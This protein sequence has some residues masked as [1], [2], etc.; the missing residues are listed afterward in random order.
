MLDGPSVTAALQSCGVSHVV[1]VPDSYLGLWE[2]ALAAADPLRLVRVCREGEG[3]AVAAGLLLGGARPVV[4]MQSTGLFEAG[5][6]LRNVVHDMKLPLFLV[7]GLRGQRAHQ[8]G[9]VGDTCPLF[10]EPIIRAWQLPH[11]LFA[12]DETAEDLAAVYRTARAAG[13]AHA[14][15]LAE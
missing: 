8:R 4:M 14:L 6:A 10:A 1:W 3:I 5:D 11:T 7:V 12:A 15:L 2:S 13:T 9:A